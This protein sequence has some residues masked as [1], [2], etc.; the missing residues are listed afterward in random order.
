MKTKSLY[1][2]EKVP[3]KGSVNSCLRILIPCDLPIH[4]E[5]SEPTPCKWLNVTCLPGGG[6]ALVFPPLPPVCHSRCPKSVVTTPQ[7]QTEER[8]KITWKSHKENELKFYWQEYCRFSLSLQQA[9]PVLE[10]GEMFWRKA[11]Y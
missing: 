4:L 9:E 1:K 7:F 10:F 6:S 2:E 11:E 3:V 8:K 5:H